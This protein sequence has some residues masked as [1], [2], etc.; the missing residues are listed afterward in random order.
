MRAIEKLD[1]ERE[2][3]GGGR[4]I[5]FVGIQRARQNEAGRLKLGGSHWPGI[6]F[7]DLAFLIGI[8]ERSM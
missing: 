1:V 2:G 7:V 3:V 8:F 6:N 4:V 5:L